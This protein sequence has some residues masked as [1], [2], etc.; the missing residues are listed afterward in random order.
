MPPYHDTRKPQT[1]DF[2]TREDM[3]EGIKVGSRVLIFDGN[4]RVYGANQ[5]HPVFRQHFYAGE[6]TGE[7]SRSWIYGWNRD[8]AKISKKTL[9]GFFSDECAG[10]QSWLSENR[11]KIA[12]SV[13]QAGLQE[14]DLL[15]EMAEKLGVDITPIEVRS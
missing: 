14:F 11:Q 10:R 1:C 5:S 3:V 13:Q 7:T 15:V 12:R 6:I 9:D 2:A 4:R 8:A